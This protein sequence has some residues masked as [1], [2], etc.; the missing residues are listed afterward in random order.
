MLPSYYDIQCTAASI[1]PFQDIATCIRM[2]KALP[3]CKKML[4]ES[5]VDVFDEMGCSTAAEFCSTELQNP[6]VNAQRSPYDVSK[7]CTEPQ[8]SPDT[9]CLHEMPIVAKFLNNET[10]RLQMGVDPEVGEYSPVS[11][12]VQST[13]NTNFDLMQPTE[14]Y[15][16]ELLERGVKV[17]IYAGTYDLV[18]NWVGN[19]RFTLAMKWTG[20]AE[21]ISK[22][23][24]DW[25]VAGKVAGKTRSANG[26][27]FVTVFG[28]G[29]MVPADK[30]KESLEMVKRWLNGNQ[31]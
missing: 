24:S 11:S 26:L 17:L 13:F 30:P 29:H 6:I 3:R 12:L 31:F 16:A 10:L 28:A 25:K 19:E 23:L 15:V 4:Q 18:C 1:K 14:F 2:K 9:V 5:C 22:P 7:V 20:Q 21:F 27:S 8:N